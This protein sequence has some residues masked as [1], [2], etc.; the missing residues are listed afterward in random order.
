MSTFRLHWKICL[1]APV[2]VAAAVFGLMAPAQAQPIK[3]AQLTQ[4][5]RVASAPATTASQP[6]QS[7]QPLSGLAGHAPA[8]G[9]RWLVSDPVAYG[10]ALKSTQWVH[11]PSGLS[12]TGCVF[13]VPS[14][15]TVRNGLITLP[16]GATQQL[17]PCAYPTLTYPGAS[18]PSTTK[19]DTP[20]LSA[21]QVRPALASTGSP[22]YFG[23]GGTYWAA[24]CNGTSPTWV[25]SMTQEQAVPSNPTKDGALIFLWGGL[26][27]ASGDTLLQDVLT[28]GA[29]GNIVTNPN[30]WYVT[31]WYLWG[32]NSVTGS[33]IHV[34]VSDTIVQALTASN[35]SSGGA[36]T[37][38][39]KATDT[40]NGLS[41]SYTV[42]SDATFT[43]I[44]GAVMEVPTA[45][46]CV[47]TPPNG[48]AAFRDLVVTGNTGTLS[49]NF[50]TS[51]PDSQ[52]SVSITQSSTGADILW[53][54]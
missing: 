12:N 15:A 39:L 26:E 28:W 32:G 1:S 36:C 2:A 43:S 29:N 19:L 31:P 11:T 27:N 45:N 44:F 52:C 9:Q 22:C 17:K 14:K 38:V 23:Q 40:T 41:T 33:S 16:S 24:S 30:I 47:E 13:H 10:Q 8:G 42:G 35:C 5:S 37:W 46:G 4:P 20:K 51:I 6:Q 21:S 34:G 7:N 53:K 50:G 48:H 3:P 18:T 54:P 49:P 25:K